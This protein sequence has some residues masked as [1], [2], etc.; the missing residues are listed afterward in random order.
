MIRGP[1]DKK[2]KQARE[3]N[4]KPA[5]KPEEKKENTTNVRED[6]PGHTDTSQESYNDPHPL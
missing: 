2:K 6:R 5:V 3:K 1:R 4:E